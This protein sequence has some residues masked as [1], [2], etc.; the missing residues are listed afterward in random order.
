M[1]LTSHN[2]VGVVAIGRNEGKRLQRCL[3]SLHNQ[4][5][6]IVYV[7]SG[8]TDGSVDLARS[9]NAEV[10]ELDLSTP[11]TAARARNAGF[12]RLLELHPDLEFVQMIDGDCELFAGFLDAA[13]Q[14]L[15]TDSTLACVCGRRRERFPQV[16]IYNT[17]CD[18]EWNTPVGPATECGGD[19]L[20]RVSALQ[21][22]HGYADDLIAGEEPE[23]CL[24]LRALGF[25]ILRIDADMTLHDAAMTSFSQWWKRNIRA[26]YAYAEGWFRHGKSPDHFRARELRSILFAA[27]ILPLLAIVPAFFTFGLTLLLLLFYPFLYLRIRKW[28]ISQGDSSATAALYSRFCV[29][30]KFPQ[31]LGILRC[32]FNR[33][34]HRRAKILEYKSHSSPITSLHTKSS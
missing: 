10:V 21:Q 33:F 1:T 8:S 27:L 32:A 7:D 31:F 18:I 5:S 25:T 3:E 12:A 16:S 6:A 22:A 26:G 9:L 34:F 14:P 29:V 17:L 11:F 24:R 2:S 20:F 28:R 19:A 23:L 15:S 4:V 30:G 13:L